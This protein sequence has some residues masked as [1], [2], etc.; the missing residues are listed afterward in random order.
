MRRPSLRALN[1]R[2]GKSLAENRSSC[3]PLQEAKF[4]APDKV[5]L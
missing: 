2:D 3:S 5:K 4:G 1:V